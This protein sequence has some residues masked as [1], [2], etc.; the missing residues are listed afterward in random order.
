ML[1]DTSLTSTA[2]LRLLFA[3]LRFLRLSVCA[4]LDL[5][6]FRVLDIALDADGLGLL[7]GVLGKLLLVC[8]LRLLDGHQFLFHLLV[9][10][11]GY[12]AT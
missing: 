12:Y 9:L 6:D 8:S 2:G 10:H 7:P 5:V 1:L 4:D 3:D 11:G